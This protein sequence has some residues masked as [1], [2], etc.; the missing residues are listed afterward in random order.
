MLTDLIK[1]HMNH[2]R[3]Q[4]VMKRPDGVGEVTG[5]VCGDSVT[6]YIRVSEGHI[7]DATFTTYGCWAAIAMGSLITEMAKGQRLEAVLELNARQLG[8]D[9]AGLP[10]DKIMCSELV[11]A[12]L[13]KAARACLA[14][15]E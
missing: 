2:P 4:C 1:D 6:V 7:R 11:F 13:H 3:N 14:F 9:L 5:P 10:E 12:A 8:Q 15:S